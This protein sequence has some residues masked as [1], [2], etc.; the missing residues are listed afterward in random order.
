VSKTTRASMSRN[1][2]FTALEGRGNNSS[3]CTRNDVK[4]ERMKGTRRW[5]G[6][7]LRYKK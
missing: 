2:S 3:S 1:S 7:V 6:S 5:G 4:H